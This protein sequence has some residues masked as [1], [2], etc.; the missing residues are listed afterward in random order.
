MDEINP[1]L[2]DEGWPYASALPVEPGDPGRFH[3]LFGRDSLITALQLLPVRPDVADAT[4]RALAARQGTREH[5]GTCEEP[6]KI[7]HEFRDRAPEQFVAAGWPD[8]G[9][10]AYYG[11][12]D[13]TSWFLVLAAR[14]PGVVAEASVRAAAAWLE[15]ALDRGDGL[16]RHAPGEWPALTQQ[17]WRDTAD[18]AA[19]YGGGIL[20]PDG[21]APE[22]P[23]ADADSQAVAYAALRATGMH[24]RAE[25]LRARLSDL[26]PDVMAIEAG[27]RPVPGA[28]SQLGWLLWADALEPAARDA[29]AE[30]LCAPD[31]LTDH[32]LRTL[33]SASPVFD[34]HA[35][36]RGSVWP[37][38]SWL[39]WGG[40]RAAGRAA[41]AER[42]RR[43]VIAALD[44]LGHAPELYAVGRDG[45][46]E[47]VPLSNRVQAWTV[48]ARWALANEWDGR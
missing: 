12:A 37:F 35:Y 9:P 30:R 18:P 2:S 10:F 28:G 44:R 40:L 39:G 46:V 19:S 8:D 24:E 36:H 42:V 43:G 25:A 32:G 48:G 33:S 3:A 45:A 1:L 14:R 16:V 15:R 13:A 20:R 4:L 26:V 41:E 38:D 31:I 6:G 7:G 23:L 21:T 29:A 5:P 27:D 47:P 22:P 11:T 17:G 34:P